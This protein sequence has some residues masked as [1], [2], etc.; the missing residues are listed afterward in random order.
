MI[1][2]QQMQIQQPKGRQAM[3]KSNSP[4]AFPSLV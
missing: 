3:D 2:K 4:I 1:Q